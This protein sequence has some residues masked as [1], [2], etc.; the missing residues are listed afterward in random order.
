VPHFLLDSGGSIAFELRIPPLAP[1]T[2][3]GLQP[4]DALGLERRQSEGCRLSPSRCGEVDAPDGL[5]VGVIRAPWSFPRPSQGADG[6]SYKKKR[7]YG[8]R[9]PHTSM[10]RVASCTH[11]ADARQSSKTASC[12]R[13]TPATD[14]IPPQG[15]KINRACGLV[16]KPGIKQA[17][18]RCFCATSEV[19]FQ[20]TSSSNHVSATPCQMQLV[21]PL[22]RTIS[23][24]AIACKHVTDSSSEGA[25]C[26]S[27]S[28]VVH[29]SQV[30]S[31]SPYMRA[32]ARCPS[33]QVSQNRDFLS[34]FQFPGN[35]YA[36]ESRKSREARPQLAFRQ[37]R[38][39]K[40]IPDEP[41]AFPKQTLACFRATT[42]GCKTRSFAKRLP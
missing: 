3:T 10:L 29:V 35:F 1:N 5:V 14:T 12:L 9:C 13:S 2:S 40:T 15:S 36:P 16:G 30:A 41:R 39:K 25:S 33:V 23:A 27:A 26:A 11:R 6:K 18:S 17:K 4:A 34:W 24:L 38:S 28:Q 32:A 19:S 7:P 31:V 22:K 21:Y 37:L 42:F 8:R 20:I